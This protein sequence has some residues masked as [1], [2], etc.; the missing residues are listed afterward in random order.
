[1]ILYMLPSCRSEWV[2]MGNN[3]YKQNTREK[4]IK[5]LVLSFPKKADLG[6]IITTEELLTAISSKVNNVLNV[7]HIRPEVEKI[8]QKS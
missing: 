8:L 6:I 2:K 7:N 3:L 1:M 5:S 4:I